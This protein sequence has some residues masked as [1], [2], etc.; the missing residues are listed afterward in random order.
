MT[1]KKIRLERNDMVGYEDIYSL[2]FKDAVSAYKKVGQDSQLNLLS[3]IAELVAHKR[4][5]NEAEDVSC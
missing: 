2:C 4:H 3:Y 5:E 1:I